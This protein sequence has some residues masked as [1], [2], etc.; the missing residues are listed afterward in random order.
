MKQHTKN[1]LRWIAVLPGS[2]ICAVLATFP[3]HWV[4]YFSLAHGETISGVNINPIEYN[5][6][7]FVI[8]S[9]FILVGQYIAP[10]YK[11]KTSIVLTSLWVFSFLI[12]LFFVPNMQFGIRG[13]GSLLGAFLGLFITWKKSRIT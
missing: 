3:L 9:T 7:P 11:F 10:K 8:A 4:L 6:Y 1:L 12:I 5:L 13:I 2:I